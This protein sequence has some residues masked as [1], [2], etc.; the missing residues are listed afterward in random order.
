MINKFAP[1][2]SYAGGKTGEIDKNCFVIT[3]YEIK[4]A[5]YSTGKYLKAGTYTIVFTVTSKDFTFKGA[6]GGLDEVYTTTYEK[7]IVVDKKVIEITNSTLTI[8]KQYDGNNELL[9]K[10]VGQNVN[11]VGGFY[12]SNGVLSGDIITVTSGTYSDSLIASGKKVTL[13]YNL[14]ADDSENYT[15]TTNVTGDITSTPLIFNK[16]GNSGDIYNPVSD[17]YETTFANDGITSFENADPMSLSYNG[18]IDSLI[19]DILASGNRLIRKGYTNT[20]WKLELAKVQSQF[21]EI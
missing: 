21:Q 17:K 1:T 4:D 7:T 9:G 5:V 10:F 18:N 14:S 13:V 20:G 2:F 15:I 8:T 11:A 16:N 19:G 12:S 6:L 3:D